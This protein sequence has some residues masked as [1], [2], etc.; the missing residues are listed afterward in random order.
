LPTLSVI[1]PVY[2]VEEFLP[3]C[4]DSLLGAGG[5]AAVGDLEVVAV[6]DASPDGCAEIL[7][8]YGAADARVRVV[9][10]AHNAG[11]G[12]ARNAGLASASGDYVWFVDSDDW[13][14]AG[15]LAAVAARLA[16]TTPDVLV[17]DYERT[18]PDGTAALRSASELVPAGLPDV[19]TLREYP[20]MLRS[21]HIAWNKVVRREFLTEHGITFG[22]GWYED[23]SFSLPLLLTAGKIS[24]LDRVCYHYRQRPGAITTTVSTRHFE[25]FPHWERVFAFLDA[26]PD[27]EDLRPLVFARMI[28]HLLAVLG[29]PERVPTDRRREFFAEMTSLYRRYRPAGGYP[30]PGGAEGLKE[31]LVG[32]GAYR[33]FEALRR[34]DRAR[35]SLLRRGS[36]GPAMAVH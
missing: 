10:L 17:V 23:V 30:V 36:V 28:W 27:C 9:T 34:V 15:A 16:A 11:L 32:L 2:R 21:L 35:K 20:A 22:P 26:H 31:R 4:L 7:A 1:V 29:H 19:F 5:E 14:A 13:L 3:D 33:T 6:D 18:Y 12:A 8:R 25:V 24:V